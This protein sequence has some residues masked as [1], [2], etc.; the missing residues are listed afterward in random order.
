MKQW[1]RHVCGVSVTLAAI[2]CGGVKELPPATQTP[3]EPS[4]EEMQRL[5]QESWE[6]GG[7]KGQP[8]LLKK[9]TTDNGS[10]K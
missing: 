4:Q 2:G 5:M 7:G 1:L 8:P 3:E 9:K 6:K 10:Q